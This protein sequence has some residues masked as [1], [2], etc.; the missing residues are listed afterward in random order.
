MRPLL[1]A[2]ACAALI[3]ACGGDADQPSPAESSQLERAGAKLVAKEN[4]EADVELTSDIP[5]QRLAMTGR[6]VSTT[7]EQRTRMTMNLAQ[8]GDPAVA[9]EVLVLDGQN[10][11]RGGPIEARLPKGKR[12]VKITD[13][14]PKPVAIGVFFAYLSEAEGFQRVGTEPIR[15][16]PTTHYRG[17]LDFEALIRKGGPKTAEGLEN[18]ARA[19]DLDATLDVWLDDADLLS[20]M[21]AELSPKGADGSLSIKV[22]VLG[23]DVDDSRLKAPKASQVITQSELAA[24]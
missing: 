14:S 20:R 23:Y 17:P 6:M 24:G 2:L 22:D 1:L 8:G 4:Y 9:L 15:G 10:F 13:D 12:W 21:E 5:G 7:D 18:I 11:V 3:A 16:K 19:G